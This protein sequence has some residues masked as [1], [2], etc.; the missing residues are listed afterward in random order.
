[1][2][3]KKYYFENYD[4][5]TPFDFNNPRYVLSLDGVDDVLDKVISNNPYTLGINDFD[6][7]DIVKLL[8][9]IDV[10]QI[11]N[12]K[13]AMAMPFFVSKDLYVLK[14]LSKH[15]AGNIADEL[16]KHKEE[17]I[18]IINKIDNGYSSDVNLYNI[19]CGYIFDG[20][21]FDYLETNNLITATCLHKSGLDYLVILYENQ[22][23]LN[24]YSDLL[25]CSYNRL[26]NNGKGF[27]SFGDSN[28]NRKDFYRYIRLKELNQLSDQVELYLNFSPEELIDNFEKL[29][30]KK[31]IEKKFI[32]A[33]EYF[34]YC[35]DGNVNIPL[36]DN[37]SREVA[38]ELYKFIL[39]LIKDELHNI[40]SVVKTEK[41]LLANSHNVEAKYIANEIYHLIF[42]EVNE[43][44]VKSGMVVEPPH[45]NGEG[46]YLR[47]FER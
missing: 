27:V 44:L 20:L 45:I 6:N 16:V 26:I 2:E 15:E 29:I 43:L 19:L 3:F 41:R 30:D 40:L 7:Q 36:Y 1:M 47:S 37:K 22:Q 31:T 42:G 34:G 35:K 32:D 11:K 9:S 39:S 23:A 38:N 4:L 8:L 14:D 24:K 28:G 21:L 25:L 17:I 18:K 10:F 12:E 13:I 5:D 33:Y 46:R